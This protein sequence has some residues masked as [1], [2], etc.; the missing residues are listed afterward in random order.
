T[1]AAFL[2]IYYSRVTAKKK[3]EILLVFLLFTFSM[4]GTW[5]VTSN[6]TSGLVE[7]RYAN[8]D[9]LGREKEDLTTG[10]GELFMKE[11]EVFI[12]N[13]FFGIGSSRAK[14]ARI[15]IDGQ[16]TTSLSEVSRT[17]SEHGMFGIVM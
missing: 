14:D 2:V 12:S 10:R 5:I 8:K 17:L 6:E 13:P 11:I 15:D 4:V 9:H 7:L 3:N 1:I 16:G